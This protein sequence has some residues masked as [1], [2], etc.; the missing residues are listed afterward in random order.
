[1]IEKC[2]VMI[3]PGFAKIEIINDVITSL[4]K[5]NMH[6]CD[7]ALIKY[8]SETAGLHYIEKRAKSYFQELIDYLV[9]DYSYGMIFEGENSVTECR[10]CVEELR[11]S[12]KEKYNLET[13]VM[14]NIIHCSSKTKVGNTYLELD[15]QREL[16][17]FYYLKDK[18]YKESL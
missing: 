12:L 9:S 17:L 11:H 15:T 10:F 2:Y 4:A 8:D 18:A 14:R 1:M 7:Q 5:I 13:D 16:E 6:I 3:K